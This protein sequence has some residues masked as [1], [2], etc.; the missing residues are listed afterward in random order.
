MTGG[1][2]AGD[3]SDERSQAM[4]WT[5][6]KPQAAERTRAVGI[7]PS[8]F[9]TTVGFR[10]DIDARQRQPSACGPYLDSPRA[11]GIVDT[12]GRSVRCGSVE[13]GFR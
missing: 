4:R 6:A 8:G 7:V 11:A 5:M 1:N 12:Q 2:C 9:D 3:I 10:A 13:E